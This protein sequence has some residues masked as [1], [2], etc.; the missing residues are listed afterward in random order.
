MSL[1]IT[2][3]AANLSKQFK[4]FAK[5]VEKDIE[6][7]VKVLAAATYAH[8]KD[9]VSNG[10]EGIKLK[11]SRDK[12]LENFVYEE[13][14]PG[15]HVISVLDRAIWIEEG[16]PNNFDMKP[17]LL[18]GPK[19][20]QGKNGKYAIV[21]FDHSKGPSRSTPAAQ[22]LSG[23]IKKELKKEGLS[24]HKIEYNSDGSP[25]VGKLHSF[26]FGGEIPGKGNTRDMQRV[27]I[28][29]TPDES[30]KSGVKRGVFTF[31]TV[32]SGPA[33]DGKW[34]HPGAEG[35]KYLDKAEQ[36]A[37]DKFESEIFPEILRKWEN[38]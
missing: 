16:L 1:K 12:F 2:I 21:P 5:E 17:G 10:P 23:R 13:V 14:S 34:I 9:L 3:D 38:K 4:E 36:W 20:K 35:K 37:M 18:G 11:S 27:S 19:A 15:L 30:R 33:S 7:G 29:Q 32:S 8:V 24:I 26:N 28:Y 31:R 25:R 6:K 22:E